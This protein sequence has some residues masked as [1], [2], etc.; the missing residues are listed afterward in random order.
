MLSLSPCSALPAF[1]ASL[2]ISLQ[3]TPLSF[4]RRHKSVITTTKHTRSDSEQLCEAEE[5]PCSSSDLRPSR[6][7]SGLEARWRRA[8]GKHRETDP[9]P[10]A[11]YLYRGVILINEM[12]L[13]ELYRQ[14]TLPN[15]TSSHH[16]Q[17]IFSHLP[18]DPSSGIP[19]APPPAR[20]NRAT[21]LG[22]GVTPH[23]CPFSARKG[24][25]PQSTP[26]LLRY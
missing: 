15:T 25:N 17:L 7:R 18:T 19:G 9:M 12:V 8:R 20:R 6:A 11:A 13:N 1:A 14:S 26:S 4:C 23:C 16:H 21:T 3:Q 5:H 2:A 22:E 10:K 24:R